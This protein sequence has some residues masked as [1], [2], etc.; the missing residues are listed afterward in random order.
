M[1]CFTLGWR[2]T[3]IKC[4]SAPTV[5]RRKESLTNLF[6]NRSE[7][8]PTIYCITTKSVEEERSLAAE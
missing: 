7:Y 4:S 1:T 5:A 2:L 3:Q 6:A 8:C